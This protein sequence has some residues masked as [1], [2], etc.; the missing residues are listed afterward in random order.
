MNSS[1]KYAC[2][3]CYS[4]YDTKDEAVKCAIEE[5]AVVESKYLCAE[6]ET[7]WNTEQEGNFCCSPEDTPEYR[8]QYDDGFPEFE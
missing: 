5:C 8:A 3:L 2:T 6:C 7:Y 4:A 1:L